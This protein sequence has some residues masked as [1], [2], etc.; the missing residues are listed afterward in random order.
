MEDTCHLITVEPQRT[1]HIG[2][3]R[4]F[5]NLKCQMNVKLHSQLRYSDIGKATRFC[6]LVVNANGKWKSQS[7]LVPQWS[8]MTWKAVRE[9]LWIK[10]HT[11]K[12]ANITELSGHGLDLHGCFRILSA[13]VECVFQPS[14]CRCVVVSAYCNPSHFLLCGPSHFQS[15]KRNCVKCRSSVC[16]LK[17]LGAGSNKP[18]SSA[19]NHVCLVMII[20]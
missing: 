1:K 14:R 7:L 8:K 12:R 9:L 19:F 2:E 10:T 17:E 13:V 18:H 11:D 6:S 4:M 16:Y 3:W 20:D 15:L 5:G